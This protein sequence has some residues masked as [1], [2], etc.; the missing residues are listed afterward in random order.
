MHFKCILELTRDQNDLVIRYDDQSP[1]ESKKIN[2]CENSSHN[3]K[4]DQNITNKTEKIS[5]ETQSSHGFCQNHYSSQNLGTR[6]LT[7]S[8]ENSNDSGTP[9]INKN[10]TNKN[11]NTRPCDCE[12]LDNRGTCIGCDKQSSALFNEELR[13]VNRNKTNFDSTTEDVF[14]SNNHISEGSKNINLNDMNINKI[15]QLSETFDNMHIIKSLLLSSSD[16]ENNSNYNVI[17]QER[18]LQNS[19]CL[20]IYFISRVTQLVVTP[21]YI[22][23]KYHDGRF[24]ALQGRDNGVENACS[25]VVLGVKLIQCLMAMLLSE[26]KTFQL[27][28]EVSEEKVCFSFLLSILS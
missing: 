25:K 8:R 3:F 2:K 15:T 10:G 4:I 9:S 26:H 6:I 18:A 14:L 5:D 24:Q 20:T 21:V 16:D 1:T 28:Y 19:V 7:D 27:E 11:L 12:Y 17:P 23:P 13:G 22:V